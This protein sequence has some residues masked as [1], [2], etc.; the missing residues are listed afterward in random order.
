MSPKII[1]L[2]DNDPT[3]SQT[4]H[5]CLL[6]LKW[7][8]ETLKKG[9]QDASPI[10]FVLTN[11][12][13]LPP[14]EARLIIREVCQ[15]LVHYI[16]KNGQRKLGD[17]PEQTDTLRQAISEKISQVIKANQIPVVH[18]SRQELAFANMTEQL[19]FGSKVSNF[20]MSVVHHL[21]RTLVGHHAPGFY[22]TVFMDG[23][24][25]AM[26]IR[27]VQQTSFG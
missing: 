23:S 18:T 11:T 16:I 24:L 7:D 15:N 27:T 12:R 19:A 21:P 6:L 2:D 5:S 9:L 26:G 22:S 8:I 25:A 17:N 10:F 4:V 1:V 13:A 3:G 20:L 14:D